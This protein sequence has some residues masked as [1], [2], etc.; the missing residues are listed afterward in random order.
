MEFYSPSDKPTVPWNLTTVLLHTSTKKSSCREFTSGSTKLN[1]SSRG[2]FEILWQIQEA[3]GLL[4]PIIKAHLVTVSIKSKN[5]TKPKK[6]NKHTQEKWKLWQS[7]NDGVSP[8]QQRSLY[9]IDLSRPWQPCMTGS[10]FRHCSLSPV[11]VQ[12]CQT[13]NTHK[14]K[15]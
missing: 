13:C 15:H 14:K 4:P 1:R 9:I 2:T 12:F 5:E 6:T 7:L 11:C 3:L 10:W 8:H